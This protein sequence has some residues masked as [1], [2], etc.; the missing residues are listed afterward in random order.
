MAPVNCIQDFCLGLVRIFYN[1]KIRIWKI[2]GPKRGPKNLSFK[3]DFLLRVS[4]HVV[5]KTPR[6]TSKAQM[7]AYGMIAQEIIVERC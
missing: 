6:Y 1:V 3:G 4:A 7:I 2:R 5:G